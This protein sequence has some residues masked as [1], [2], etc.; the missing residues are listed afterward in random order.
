MPQNFY[1]EEVEG[2]GSIDNNSTLDPRDS[3]SDRFEVKQRSTT[4]SRIFNKNRNYSNTGGSVDMRSVPKS[5]N[6]VS[7]EK[8][9]S[10]EGL[11][12]LFVPSADMSKYDEQKIENNRVSNEDMESSVSQG[13]NGRL[14]VKVEGLSFKPDYSY[15]ETIN[16]ARKVNRKIKVL[17]PISYS[18][19]KDITVAFKAGN[20]LVLSLK[21][22]DA[23]I[24]NKILDFALGASSMCNAKVSVEANKTYVFNSG[25]DLTKEEKLE[26]IDQG[27][28]FKS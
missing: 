27:V 18:S 12:S 1:N 7:I 4:S 24:A 6:R 9:Y 26:C 21:H 10:S 8:P 19:V 23:K 2:M 25:A 20:I 13:K 28:T 17:K 15:S 16:N 5:K 3:F 14:Q 22:T 11:N